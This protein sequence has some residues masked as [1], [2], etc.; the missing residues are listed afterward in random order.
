MSRIWILAGAFA[1]TVVILVLMLFLG[2]WAFDYRR[3]SQHEGRLRRVLEERPSIAQLTEGLESEGASVVADPSTAEAV[4]GVIAAH[5]AAKAAELRERAR[6]W[7][8]VRVFRA[9]DMLYFVFYD[10]QGVMR[11]FTCVSR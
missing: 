1:A 10:D 8:H 4:E 9:A 11:D 3:F 7:G 6:R 5:G 2:S